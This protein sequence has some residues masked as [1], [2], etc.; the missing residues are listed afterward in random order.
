MCLP[1][2][3]PGLDLEISIVVT[4]IC[5][6]G[7]ANFRNLKTR[8]HIYIFEEAPRMFCEG[9]KLIERKSEKIFSSRCVVPR[10]QT[11]FAVVNSTDPA[12]RSIGISV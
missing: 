10:A 5:V 12:I 7:K 3:V 4:S 2:V 8:D 11:P 6:E 9:R 1:S